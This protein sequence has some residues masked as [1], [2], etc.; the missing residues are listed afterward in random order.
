M[1]KLKNVKLWLAVCFML[2]IMVMPF[3]RIQAEAADII[4]TVQ[5]TIS[6]KTSGNV[7]YLSTNEGM[8]QIKIDQSTDVSGIKV[9]N[10]NRR[11]Y[12]SVAYGNDSYLHAVKIFT[13]EPEGNATVDTTNTF[14]ASGTISTKSTDKML[15]FN[16]PGSGEMHIKLD[17]TTK[18]NAGPVLLVNKTYTITCGRGSDAYLHAVIIDDPA[19]SIGSGSTSSGVSTGYT[20]TPANAVTAQTTVFTGTIGN[21]TTEKLLCLNTSGGEMQIVIDANTDS[22]LGMVLTPGR[23]LTLTAYRGSDA[24]MHAAVILGSKTAAAAA[25]IDTSSPMTVTG[26]VS[27][28]ST[29]DVLYLNT[30][31]GEM[32]LKLD[33]VSS[34]SNCKVLTSGK[35]ITVSCARGSD[36]YL[37]AITIKGN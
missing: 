36:A 23:N 19:G 11:I 12:V 24:Y 16:V 32:I 26:T 20:P 13:D 14:K 3:N 37:H 4:A 29:E 35:Q 18:M 21:N 30:A 10:P 1:K 31:Q 34:V 33:A 8:M 2:G 5:G 22:R 17:D 6:S 15:Y 9:L 7:L 25:Q 27:S 28:K